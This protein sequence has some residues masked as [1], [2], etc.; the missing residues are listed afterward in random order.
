[1]NEQPPSPF[2]SLDLQ[3]TEIGVFESLEI[4]KYHDPVRIETTLYRIHLREASNPDYWDKR[5]PVPPQPALATISIWQQGWH[6]VTRILRP[7]RI[8]PKDH[9]KELLERALKL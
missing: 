4:V 7:Q 9:R 1:M 2:E 8:R 6:E 3:T 5:Y